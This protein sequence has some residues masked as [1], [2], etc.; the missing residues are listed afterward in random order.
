VALITDFPFT[1]N[2]YSE[3]NAVGVLLQDCFG[4]KPHN[5]VPYDYLHLCGTEKSPVLYVEHCLPMSVAVYAQYN[6]LLFTSGQWRLGISV[7]LAFTVFLLLI[8]ENMPKTSESVP[9]LG[10]Y[11]Y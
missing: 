9:L 8:A 5:T 3:I 7:L 4:V 6:D 11:R 2:S 10:L 1:K